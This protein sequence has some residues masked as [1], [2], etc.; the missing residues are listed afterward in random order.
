MRIIQHDRRR[1]VIMDRRIVKTREAIKKAY[2][3]L[4]TEK[5]TSKISISELARRANIDRKTFYLHYGSTDDV[6]SE[7]VE[8]RFNT[9]VSVMEEHHYFEDPFNVEML[10]SLL[11]RFYKEEEKMLL[12]VAGSDSYDDLWN[13]IH[14][15]LA[16]KVMALYA[17]LVNIDASEISVFYDYFTAGVIDVYR[18]WSRKEYDCD[19]RH[20]VEMIGSVAQTG[21]YPFKK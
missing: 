15:I 18:R 16:D 11:D 13:K 19:L 12:S 21:L 6:L 5:G 7:Y 17:P 3:D 14:D 10:I 8:N 9:I 20:L 4:I 2:L 1:C